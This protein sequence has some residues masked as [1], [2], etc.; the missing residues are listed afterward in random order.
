VWPPRPVKLT[1]ITIN[2]TITTITIMTITTI[3]IT[4]MIIIMWL[5]LAST[6]PAAI[7]VFAPGRTAVSQPILSSDRG[8]AGGGAATPWEAPLRVLGRPATTCT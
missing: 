5:T 4:I 6:Q 7:R 8:W 3:I 2:I 1:T